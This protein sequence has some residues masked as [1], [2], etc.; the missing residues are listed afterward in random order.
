MTPNDT[1]FDFAQLLTTALWIMGGALALA[2]PL[3]AWVIWRVRRIKLPV[4]ADFFT[5]LRHTPF[6]VV[7]LLDLLDLGLDFLSAPIAWV[8]LTRLGLAPLR[9]VT[10]IEELIPGTQIIPTMTLA[11]VAVRFLGPRALNK[12]IH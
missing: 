11:W 4:N 9:G 12:T 5:A 10:I 8:L 7:L 2:L 3:L 1:G 6:V